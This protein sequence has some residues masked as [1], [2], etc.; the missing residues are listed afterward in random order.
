MHANIS[1]FS[2]NRIIQPHEKCKIPIIVYLHFTSPTPSQDEGEV[3]EVQTWPWGWA[4]PS[5][6][7]PRCLIPLALVSA[8]LSPWLSDSLC[9][10][11]TN[12]YY[13]NFKHS[14]VF[15]EIIKTHNCLCVCA[16]KKVHWPFCYFLVFPEI[17]LSYGIF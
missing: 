2:S 17:W 5:V 14:M 1:H 13:I 8:L 16:N 10:G 4:P 9:Y 6:L 12:C 7:R 3:S 11:P 15:K